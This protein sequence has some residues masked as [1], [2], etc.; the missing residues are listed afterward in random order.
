MLILPCE[1]LGGMSYFG[2]SLWVLLCSLT[3]E[4]IWDKR[5][6]VRDP[7]LGEVVDAEKKGNHAVPRVVLGMFQP[8]TDGEKNL[9]WN[10]F[11][12]FWRKGGKNNRRR[13]EDGMDLAA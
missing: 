9:E 13:G 1:R 8:K 12:F 3:L 11:V 5:A 10:R 7:S 2:C 4:G 6:D